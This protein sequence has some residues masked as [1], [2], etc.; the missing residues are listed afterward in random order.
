MKYRVIYCDPS[1]F[2]YDTA[3]KTFNNLKDA[4]LWALDIL[5]Q[6]PPTSHSSIV[7]EKVSK[8]KEISFKDNQDFPRN[9]K[10]FNVLG[11]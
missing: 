2:V 6:Y 7:I 4:K 5:K 8:V 3:E 1:I 11:Q 9:I 10:E